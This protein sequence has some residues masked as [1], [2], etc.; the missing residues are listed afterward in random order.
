MM[1][2]VVMLLMRVRGGSLKR[3]QRLRVLRRRRS[4]LKLNWRRVLLL[5]S[6]APTITLMITPQLVVSLLPSRKIRLVIILIPPCFGSLS[7]AAEVG[8]LL[9]TS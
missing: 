4:L 6:K 3:R 9:F 5:V 2:R 8:F 1:T 7:K